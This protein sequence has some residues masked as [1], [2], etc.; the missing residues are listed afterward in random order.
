MAGKQILKTK[1]QRP[2][3]NCFGHIQCVQDKLFGRFCG[4]R[5]PA[6]H[7]TK[8]GEKQTYAFYE[9][10]HTSISFLIAIVFEGFQPRSCQAKNPEHCGFTSQESHIG[11]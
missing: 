6:T 5:G 4:C 8:P 7:G 2:Q 11:S 10:T 9:T 1:V 3:R